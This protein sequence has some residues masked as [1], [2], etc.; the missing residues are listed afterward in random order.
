[1]TDAHEQLNTLALPTVDHYWDAG[2]PTTSE[3]LKLLLLH[4]TA[5]ASWVMRHVCG[6][7]A[8]RS[9]GILTYHRIARKKSGVPSPT[10][11]VTP[12]KFRRQLTGLKQAGFNFAS[13]S[14]V[15]V[16]ASSRETAAQI[17]ER[18]VVVTFD[19]IYDNVFHNAWPVLQELEIPATFFVSTA[20][21]DSPQPFLFDRWARKYAGQV[22]SKT[23]RPIT[24]AHLQTMLQTGLAE[25]GA[26]T[27]T[28]QDFRN[29]T[30]DFTTD[31]VTGINDLRRRYG[32]GD[33]SFAFPY[34]CPRKG[35]CAKP[36]MQAAKA[37]GL[38]CAL[39]T[40]PR[41]NGVTTSPFG[42]GRFHVFNHDTPNSLAAKLDGWH[43]WLPKLKNKL[44]GTSV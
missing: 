28:H 14:S 33:L 16:A 34:G 13:L 41:N 10:I 20:F 25:V 31:L 15:L 35:F 1:M 40:G 11:N 2:E 23:W 19:D 27:H 17:P 36:L 7:L 42:W 44:I 26:H 18:T 6:R 37:A 30:D 24:D 39:T 38:R 5:A 12:R 4:Q 43:D 9:I 21:I 8:K 29:R 22:S 3:H 32:V